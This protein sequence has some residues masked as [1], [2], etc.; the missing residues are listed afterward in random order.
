MGRAVPTP[1][2]QGRRLAA[3]SRGNTSQ[4]PTRNLSDRSPVRRPMSDQSPAA[5][6]HSA[7][8]TWVEGL[9]WSAGVPYVHLA[10]RR[11]RHVRPA[12]QRLL[13]RL[14]CRYR[15]IPRSLSASRLR[16]FGHPGDGEA[17]RLIELRGAPVR[18]CCAE[19]QRP[20]DRFR[21]PQGSRVKQ[22]LN[23]EH[24]EGGPTNEDRNTDRRR[25][26]DNA[27]PGG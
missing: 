9:G 7:L 19:G 27:S 21:S 6:A 26:V 17:T 3:F 4:V 14:R 11:R 16:A 20:F 12:R 23:T 5:R 25:P 13:C 15:R 1:R 22:R 2:R 10:P 24:P 8:E 18:R